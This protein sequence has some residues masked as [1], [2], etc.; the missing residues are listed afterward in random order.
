MSCLDACSSKLEC[1]VGG[2]ITQRQIP[3]PVPTTASG[4]QGLL[5]LVSGDWGQGLAVG[6]GHGVTAQ[7]PLGV[8]GALSTPALRWPMFRVLASFCWCLKRRQC[9]KGMVGAILSGLSGVRFWFVKDG[10]V[11]RRLQRTEVRARRRLDTVIAATINS[12]SWRLEVVTGNEGRKTLHLL[13][14]VLTRALRNWNAK[15]VELSLKDRYP[16]P[17]PQPPQVSKVCCL[18]YL[19]IWDKDWLWGMGATW[20][21]WCTLN[22]KV[23]KFSQAL[24]DGGSA[25]DPF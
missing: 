8:I 25:H 6:D 15:W 17:C 19:G 16:C 14:P 7:R 1:K 20:R 2:N 18:W 13:C 3:L 4:L 9:P 10:L 22:V 5:S 23:W 12:A 21:H 24:L 11:R